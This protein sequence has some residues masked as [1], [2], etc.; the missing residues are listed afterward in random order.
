L[1]TL[2]GGDTFTGLWQG[3][4][5][6]GIGYGL[7]YGGLEIATALSK[8][9]D[10]ISDG[11]INVGYQAATTTGRSV[12]VNKLSGK[13]AFSSLDIGVGD[14]T[15]HFRDGKLSDNLWQN[16][17]NLTVTYSYSRGFID[18]ATGKANVE[19]DRMAVGPRFIETIASQKGGYAW[20]EQT[21]DPRRPMVKRVRFINRGW[22]G[23]SSQGKDGVN[24]F[25]AVFIGYGPSNAEATFHH[26][27][28]HSIDNRLRGVLND[29]I[30][31]RAYGPGETLG[32][33][34]ERNIYRYGARK[35]PE[36]GIGEY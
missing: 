24:K 22:T 25:G 9:G 33:Y 4:L 21:A 29:D 17:D 23:R 2:S 16:V 1:A 8:N 14:F 6:A 26:E 28:L 15:L 13:G 34:Y 5:V 3:A 7:S 18:V 31:M 35:F 10:N 20:R 11:L 19:Y 32:R 12:L 30:Y 36:Y 27:A